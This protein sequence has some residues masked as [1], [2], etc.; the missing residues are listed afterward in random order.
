MDAI[1]L[2]LQEFLPTTYCRG[3]VLVPAGIGIFEEESPIS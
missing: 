2:V 3:Y 1:T